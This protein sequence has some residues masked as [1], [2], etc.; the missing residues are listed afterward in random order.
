M[1]STNVTTIEQFMNLPANQQYREL[2]FFNSGFAGL[3][4]LYISRFGAIHIHHGGVKNFYFKNTEL[5]IDDVSRHVILGTQTSYL[6]L[7]FKYDSYFY[8]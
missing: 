4:E 6:N 2:R 3:D 7:D 5:N 8:V 1:S